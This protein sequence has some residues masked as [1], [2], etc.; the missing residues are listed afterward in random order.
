[1][2]DVDSEST[3]VTKL[4]LRSLQVVP[5]KDRTPQAPRVK[6][7]YAA[8]CNRVDKGVTLEQALHLENVNGQWRAKIDFG[9]MP[10]QDSPA[11]AA[12][13]LA[14]WMEQMAAVLNAHA[15]EIGTIQVDTL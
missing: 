1:M 6:A 4:A 15:D 11:D 13:K 9:D 5:R 8:S 10:A 7:E 3:L 2:P 12:L 14:S